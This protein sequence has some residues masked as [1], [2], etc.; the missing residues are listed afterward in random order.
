M[1]EGDEREHTYPGRN[2]QSIVLAHR[3]LMQGTDMGG[4]RNGAPC[5][6]AEAVLAEAMVRRQLGDLHPTCQLSE[7]HTL[8]ACLEHAALQIRM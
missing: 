7:N 5:Y 8:L 4:F 6:D 1:R 3:K 2:L